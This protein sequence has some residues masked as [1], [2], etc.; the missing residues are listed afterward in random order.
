MDLTVL[1]ICG[2]LAKEYQLPAN[3]TIDS[4]Y[5]CLSRDAEVNYHCKNAAF[6]IMDSTRCHLLRDSDAISQSTEQDAYGR[7][8]VHFGIPVSVSFVVG[9]QL[10][11][12]VTIVSACSID[13]ALRLAN[14][15]KC[16][17]NNV[18]VQPVASTDKREWHPCFALTVYCSEQV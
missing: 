7:F 6:Q 14:V 13:E 12:S 16:M 11:E 3:A 17:V 18:E 4:L 8:V 15:G 10:C 1:A 9:G 5:M 2:Q